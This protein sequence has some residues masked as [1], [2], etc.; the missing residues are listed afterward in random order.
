MQDLRERKI[1]E[2][3]TEKK[4]KKKQQS[5]SERVKKKLRVEPTEAGSE[6]I[7]VCERRAEGGM[8]DPKF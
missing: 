6:R 2:N 1:L 7:G 4:K 5:D 8:R 3:D